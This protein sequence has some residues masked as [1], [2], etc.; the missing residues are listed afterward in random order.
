MVRTQTEAK[1]FFVDKV[2]A[3]AG[4]EGMTLSDA[5]RKMLFWS[6]SDPD[7]VVDLEFR[8]QPLT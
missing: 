1:R 3:Q 8:R 7:W 6:E 4:A 5:E 2:L